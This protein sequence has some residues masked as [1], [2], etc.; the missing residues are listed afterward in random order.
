MR[1]RLWG[2]RNEVGVCDDSGSIRGR[3]WAA[4]LASRSDGGAT[5]WLRFPSNS[6][7]AAGASLLPGFTA[8]R[9]REA[10]GMRIWGDALSAPSSAESPPLEGSFSLLTCEPGY[11]FD[12]EAIA[13]VRW[14]DAHCWSVGGTPGGQHWERGVF[15][16]EGV[17][18][19]LG[20]SDLRG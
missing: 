13:C 3:L 7:S 1:G 14:E 15:Q 6:S 12:A 4:K 16:I 2:L 18:G 8:F 10:A 17:P 5:L 19:L 9:V 11:L 20:S